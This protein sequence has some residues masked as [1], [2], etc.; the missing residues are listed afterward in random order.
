MRGI[1][2]NAKL[3]LLITTASGLVGT[4][5]S[6]PNK[7]EMIELFQ[8]AV[9]GKATGEPY[10]AGFVHYCLNQ[11]VGA[12]GNKSAIHKSE[13]VVEMWERTPKM[14]RLDKPD[15]GS[16][17]C[18]QFYKNGKPTRAGHC[19]IVKEIIDESRVLV[20]EG[21]TSE[22]DQRVI[23][24]GNGV[25]LKKRQILGSKEMKVLGWLLPWA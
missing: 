4:R 1:V 21:N 7:G 6:G 18:W 15:V 12:T 19:G 25:W 14:C 23:R 9:D 11:V 10:C 22:P 13:S 20:I 16:I 17:M 2:L 8:K 24:E 5:E 3:D